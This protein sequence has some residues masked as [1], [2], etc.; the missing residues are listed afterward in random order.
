MC[1]ILGFSGYVR[2]GQWSETYDLLNALLVASECRG[3]DATGFVAR[4]EPLKNCLAANIV[5]DKAPMPASQF[6]DQN[7]SW[8]SLKHTRSSSCLLHVRWATHGSPADNRNNHPLVGHSSLYL[9][10][11]GVLTDHKGTAEK[12]GLKL[13][14]DCDSE[15]ILRM[16]ESAKHPAVGLDNALRRVKGSMAA[17]V[18]DGQRDCLY[19]ARDAGRPLWL[20]RLAHDRRWWFASTREILLAA[21]EAVLGQGVMSKVETL[22]PL[23]AGSVHVLTNSGRLISLPNG[24]GE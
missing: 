10:H 15:L 17:V 11:N 7:P 1:G 8:R 4:T 5:L 12:H 6:I 16:V 20:M 22:F 9:V 3:K 24:R 18:Y 14:T 13:Q 2:E 21:M 23:A 19:L